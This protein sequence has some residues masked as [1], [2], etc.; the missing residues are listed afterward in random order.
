VKAILLAI[1]AVYVVTNL[2]LTGMAIGDSRSR[3]DLA[4]ALALS[5]VWMLVLIYIVIDEFRRH[6]VA[7]FR[8]IDLPDKLRMRGVYFGR[9]AVG[10]VWEEKKRG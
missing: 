6:H 2:V 7:I 9:A 4:W 8:T 1:F 5:P 10:I 3:K